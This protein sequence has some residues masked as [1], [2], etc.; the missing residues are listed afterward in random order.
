MSIG[1][2]LHGGRA[3][4]LLSHKKEMVFATPFDQNLWGVVMTLPT[5]DM[6]NRK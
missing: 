6:L 1:Y 4:E 5:M 2:R 3:K